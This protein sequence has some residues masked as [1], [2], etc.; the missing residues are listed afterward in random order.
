MDGTYMQAHD[1]PTVISS[2]IVTMKNTLR[3]NALLRC[4]SGREGAE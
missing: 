4:G 3:T 2:W 1:T